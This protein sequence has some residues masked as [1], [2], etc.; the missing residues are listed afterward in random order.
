MPDF[1]TLIYILVVTNAV[2]YAAFAF[3]YLRRRVS[4]PKTSEVIT[5]F[6]ILEDALIRSF[7]DLPKGFTWEEG[8]VR[9]K[10]L[11]LK[12]KWPEID[13]LL[14]KYESYRYGTNENTNA[15]A[16]EVLKLAYSLPRRPRI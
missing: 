7:P 10:N 12:V 16:H 3:W 13:E 9:A 15:N 14:M 5:A 4:I 6:S 8:I 2:T 1:S 11:N